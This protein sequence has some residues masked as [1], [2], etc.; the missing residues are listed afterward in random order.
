MMMS[1][2]LIT[3]SMALFQCNNL[4]INRLFVPKNTVFVLMKIVEIITE[5]SQQFC[6]YNMAAANYYLLSNN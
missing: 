6:N 2:M 1:L 3:L 4:P 5:L